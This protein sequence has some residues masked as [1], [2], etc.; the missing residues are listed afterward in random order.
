ML[1][2]QIEVNNEPREVAQGQSLKELMASLQ[3]PTEGTAVAVDDAIVPKSQWDSFVLTAG[4]KVD[5]FS[6]VAGG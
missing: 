4:M 6:L 3:F 5:V 1:T 2:M